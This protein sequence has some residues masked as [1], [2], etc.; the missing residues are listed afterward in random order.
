MIRK[1]DRLTVSVIIPT[2]NRPRD[3]SGTIQNL[4]RQS[5][6]P[7]QLI[8]VDQSESCEGR[9]LVRAAFH[10]LPVERR[11]NID[12][13]HISDPS[14]VGAATA[15]NCAMDIADGDI[16]LFLDDDVR[17]DPD[18]IKEVISIYE[19]HQNIGGVAGIITNYARPGFGYRCWSWIFEWGPFHDERQPIYWNAYRL[20]DSAPIRV[21]KFTGCAMSFKASVIGDMRF[22]QNLRGASLAEDIDF[23]ARLESARLVVSPR[24]RVAH[25]RSP[26][27]RARDHWIR[28]HALSASYMYRRNWAHGLTNRVCFRWLQAGEFLVVAMSCL[29]RR[30]LDPLHA[31]QAGLRQ[32]SQV[33]RGAA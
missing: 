5:I 16:W 15:R 10:A 29:R 9:D 26:M 32:A 12:L 28:S 33:T 7:K 18:F 31:L 17:L 2:K 23:C 3:L 20:R 11:E 27:N 8:I 24:A 30:S 6:L 4:F 13:C 25:M 1:E 19:K 22:D 21:R 14:I